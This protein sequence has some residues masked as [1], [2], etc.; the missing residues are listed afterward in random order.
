MTEPTIS[1]SL[2]KD[3]SFP[4][5]DIQDLDKPQ[6][7]I[8]INNLGNEPPS[9]IQISMDSIPD[10][11]TEDVFL[12]AR[13]LKST[14]SKS[15]N[16]DL[17]KTTSGF[18]TLD[19]INNIETIDLEEDKPKSMF[20]NLFGS[21]KKDESKNISSKPVNLNMPKTF[22]LG[23]KMNDL[24][25]IGK[26][27]IGSI[28]SNPSNLGTFDNLSDLNTFSKIPLN[29]SMNT[30]KKPELSHEEKLKQ[31]LNYLRKLEALEKKGIAISKRYNINDPLDEMIGEYEMIKSE[32]EKK[33]SIKFQSQMLTAAIS[34][35]EFLNN[36]FD[37]FDLNL[38]GWSE[39]IN[40]QINEYDDVFGELHEKYSSKAKI[41]PELKLLFM[42]GGS[43]LMVHMT[44]TMFKSAMPGMDDIMRQNPDLMQH[45]T[46]AAVNTMGQTNPGF[47]NFA[48]GILNQNRGGG[49]GA[50]NNQMPQRQMPPRGSP[51]GP[52]PQYKSNPPDFKPMN[53]GRPDVGMSRGRPNFNDA[54]NM[55]NKFASVNKKS[56]RREM[57]GPSSEVNALFS[58]LK[59]K[60]KKINI[61][62]NGSTASVDDLKEISSMGLNGLKPKKTKRK[63]KSA[64][65]I[66]SL[67]L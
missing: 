18:S 39:S 6:E 30:T 51:P 25:D 32:Q 52:P 24:N 3:N 54:V 60:T 47:G 26:A 62:N 12:N 56:T 29:P 43:G 15:K 45:F 63:L 16:I 37:P 50:P 41:A 5:L 13:N 17:N 38:D 22:S 40:E 20:S 35:L 58:G 59:I 44:N 33:N 14:P 53:T 2:K 34:G 23:G 4:S 36:K 31:K 65:N 61:K 27:K 28:S 67:Q 21:G 11:P 7:T 9:N 8:K 64:K 48:S 42:I 19:D 1:I 49:G 46:Q 66:M 57:K 55:D 10:L